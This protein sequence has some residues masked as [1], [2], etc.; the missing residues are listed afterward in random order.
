LDTIVFKDFERRYILADNTKET[1]FVIDDRLTRLE[2]GMAAYPTR[3]EMR[4][5]LKI[6]A[7]NEYLSKLEQDLT[8]LAKNYNNLVSAYE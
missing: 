6:K 1:G 4:E 3:N 2:R 5:E 7:T 8:H